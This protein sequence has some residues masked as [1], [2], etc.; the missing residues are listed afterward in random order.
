[1]EPSVPETVMGVGPKGAPPATLTTS[2]A[3]A[4]PLEGMLIGL[5]VKLENDTPAG[6]L[7]TASVTDPE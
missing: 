5:G 2:T 6:E 4:V 3:E 1:M 7:V